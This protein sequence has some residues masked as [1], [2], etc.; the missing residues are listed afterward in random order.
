[1]TRAIPWML[2]ITPRGYM[3]HISPCTNSD[4]GL[5]TSTSPNIAYDPHADEFLALL[6]KIDGNY[7]VTMDYFHSIHINHLWKHKIVT[8][9]RLCQTQNLPMSSISFDRHSR[10]QYDSELAENTVRMGIKRAYISS[11]TNKP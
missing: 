7:V 1:M 9:K 11:N 2:C 5:T 4:T 3:Y 6:A 8:S 10:A